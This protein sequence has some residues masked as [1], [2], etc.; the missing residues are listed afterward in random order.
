M[1]GLI[2]VKPLGQLVNHQP[3]I[4]TGITCKKI[5]LYA[6]LSLLGV[7]VEN[8]KIF[9]SY[10]KHIWISPRQRNSRILIGLCK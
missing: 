6:Q 3:I 2:T 1:K 10:V 9:W 5:L 7:I 4:W 8:G